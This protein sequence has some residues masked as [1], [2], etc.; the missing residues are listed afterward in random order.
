MKTYGLTE[1]GSQIIINRFDGNI[2]TYPD[3][4]NTEKN[5]RITFIDLETTGLDRQ[6]D[7]VI[8]LG[9]LHFNFNPECGKIVEIIE[10]YN[11]LQNPGIPIPANITKLTGITTDMVIDQKIDM[12]KVEK[13]LSGSDMIISHNAAFDR[14]FTDR[15]FPIS[16]ERLWGCSMTQVNWRE[17]GCSSRSQEH[18]CRD[19]GFFYQAH[20]ALEDVKAAINLL[21][22]ESDLSG[23]TYLN[24]LYKNALKPSWFVEATGAPFEVKDELKNKRFR[25]NPQKRVWG[26]QVQDEEEYQ[27]LLKWMDETIY[28][29]RRKPTIT[30]INP[31]NRF[32]LENQK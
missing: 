24:I 14:P 17:E 21:G 12:E 6:N 3:K 13:I 20:R 15:M 28:Q 11:S 18:L 10:E 25:W 26:I 27:E 5:L 29:G 8:E 19:H 23:E 31:V 16:Q 32:K 9:L 1:D 30:E 7:L 2:Q 4:K 22:F